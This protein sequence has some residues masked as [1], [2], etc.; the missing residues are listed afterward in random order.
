MKYLVGARRA[1][2][3]MLALAVTALAGCSDAT[4]EPIAAGGNIRIEAAMTTPSVPFGKGAL[5]NDAGAMPGGTVDSLRI[6]RMRL[7]VSEIRMSASGGGGDHKVQTGP[8]LLMVD[9]T[10]PHAVITGTVPARSFDKI[11]FKFHRLDE[12][13]VA[14][15]ST[16]PDFAEFVTPLRPTVIIDGSV[17]VNG[18]SLPFKYRS[19]VEQDLNLDLTE[20]GVAQNGVTVVAIQLDPV[21]LFKE[22]SN[23]DV[24]DPRDPDN[25]NRIDNAIRAALRAMKK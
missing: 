3:G 24:L 10:G 17:Y 6:I 8:G 21:A 22:Q 14:L 2:F 11:H 13:E 12:Q 9:Q 1:S 16:N 18:I 19:R 20:F 15:F 7:L 23:R 25:S 5:V 4:T